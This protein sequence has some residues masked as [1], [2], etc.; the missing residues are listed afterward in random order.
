MDFKIQKQ[1]MMR[2]VVYALTPIFL[3]SIYLYGYR[4]LT[5]MAITI[6]FG[7][8]SEY[9][10]ERILKRKK[11]V[12][13]TEA[14]LVTS[15][16][17][18]LSMP[19]ALGEIQNLWVVAIGIIFGMV[20]GKMV[21]GGF[22]RNIFN[23]A[24]AGRLF[25]FLAFPTLLTS[26]WFLGGNWGLMQNSSGSDVLTGATPLANLKMHDIEGITKGIDSLPL[27][28]NLFLG[29]R[30]GSLGESSI[31]LIVLAAIYLVWTKTAQLRLILSPLVGAFLTMLS[32]NYLPSLLGFEPINMAI[33]P[34]YGM[35]VGSLAFASVFMVTE[36][37]SAP[38]KPSAQIVYG[39]LIGILVAIIRVFSLLPESVTFAVIIGNVF[40]S[41]IDE[42]MPKAKDP[43]KTISDMFIKVLFVVSL[44]FYFCVSPWGK[45]MITSFL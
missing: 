41:L 39:L 3:F 2:R 5:I 40:A 37:V 10:M 23:P 20:F 4:S 42:M 21:Y 29:T 9:I 13:V 11:D 33:D 8:L 34:F 1:P 44:I 24:L 31:L 45:A 19:P 30:S 7:Y 14:F 36:P 28:F 15:F 17:F 12:K 43:K 16:L 6:I 27:W 35:M 38:N 32:L 22:G 18:A 26:H 25:V